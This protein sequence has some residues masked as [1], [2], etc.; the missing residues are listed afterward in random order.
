VHE[1]TGV[2]TNVPV[3]ILC[4]LPNGI[5]GNANCHMVC[6]PCQWQ[7]KKENQLLKQWTLVPCDPTVANGCPY[8]IVPASALYRHCFVVPDELIPGVVFEVLE[9]KEWHKLF[10]VK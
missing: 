9:T 3:K 5:P 2:L 4:F 8:D 6:H 1:T 7:N 10:I